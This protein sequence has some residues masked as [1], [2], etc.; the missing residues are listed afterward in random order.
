MDQ[1]ILIVSIIDVVLIVIALAIDWL[2]GQ[3]RATLRRDA[4]FTRT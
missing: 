4:G 2:N 1:T 3:R